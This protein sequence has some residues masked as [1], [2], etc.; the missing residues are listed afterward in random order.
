MLVQQTLQAHNF[1][2]EKEFVHAHY[3]KG[4]VWCG[5]CGSRLIF[6]RNKGK[7]GIVYDYFACI[8]RHRKRNNCTRKYVLTKDVEQG[9]IEFY[10]RFE[11]PTAPLED[12]NA[13]VVDEFA[14]LHGVAET[15]LARSR[16]RLQRAKDQRQK[17]LSAVYEDA[18]PRDMLQSEMQRLTAEIASAEAELATSQAKPVARAR[19]RRRGLDVRGIHVDQ[20]GTRGQCDVQPTQEPGTGDRPPRACGDS[21]DVALQ[22]DPITWRI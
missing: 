21:I 3:L 14:R 11:V 19:A 1:A 5:G 18:I 16:R 7:T 17:L 15:D 8:G 10:K 9:V 2:G 20:P 4:T 12:V 13:V 22:L 6:S